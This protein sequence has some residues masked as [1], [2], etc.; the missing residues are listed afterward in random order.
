VRHHSALAVGAWSA[1]ALAGC[2]PALPDVVLVTVDTLRPDRLSSYAYP[3]HQ[4]PGIDRLAAE[5]A[6]FW[7][8]LADAP[9]TTPSMASVLTGRYATAHGLKSTSVHR[10]AD[11]SVTLAEIL[12]QH[13]YDTAAVVGSFP[14]DSVFRLDQ[15]FR[16]YDDEYTRPIMSVPGEEKQRI[17]DELRENPE[18]RAVFTLWKAAT[19]AAT[20]PR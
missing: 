1:L 9:W 17:E 7:Y 3:R 2:A 19:A 16:H 20:T 4:T 12:A 15:G 5:G 8:A 10:L 18:D 6:L 13:G 11:E 14:V